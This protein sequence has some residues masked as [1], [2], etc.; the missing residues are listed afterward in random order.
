MGAFFLLDADTRDQYLRLI[1]SV[2]LLLGLLTV[3]VLRSFAVALPPPSGKAVTAEEAP[4]LFSLL[5]EVRLKLGAPSLD[6]V[7]ISD[8]LNA[9][10]TQTRRLGLIGPARNSLRMGLPLLEGLGLDEIKAVIAHEY[11]HLAGA[12]GRMSTWVYFLRQRLGNLAINF[13]SSG[14]RI[15]DR[16]LKW[17]IPF[18]NAH[19]LVLVRELELR[20]DQVAARAVGPGAIGLSLVRLDLMTVALERFWRSFWTAAD[21]GERQPTS[22][23]YDRMGASLRDGRDPVNEQRTLTHCLGLE[24]DTSHM[25]P[26]LSDRLSSLRA[27]PELPPKIGASA[28]EDLLGPSYAAVVSYWNDKW[29]EAARET[30]EA[31]HAEAERLRVELAGLEKRAPAD[32]KTVELLRLAALHERIEDA[33]RAVK[34]YREALSREPEMS[35]ALFGLGKLLLQKDDPEGVELLERAGWKAILPA[36]GFIERYFLRRGD[37][38][39]AKVWRQKV[40]TAAE[41]LAAA[42]VERANIA[43]DATLATHGWSDEEVHALA[44]QLAAVKGL[45][46]AWLARIEVRYLPEEPCYMLLVEP[47]SR[48][49]F[50]F[51]HQMGLNLHVAHAVHTTRRCLI[52]HGGRRSRLRQ[53]LAGVAN[54]LVYDR[55]TPGARSSP[56]SITARMG[57][58]R[59][60]VCRAEASDEAGE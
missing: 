41:E 29:W 8:E 59:A 53:R 11:A 42:Q 55:P 57:G 24:H 47:R 2:T 20:A 27:E 46:R 38:A 45:K 40:A 7:L 12:H 13:A 22:R 5:E 6:A 35:E 30:W 34:F 10:V 19:S 39:T 48:V 52:A 49:W 18:F 36:G 32:L 51:A 9:G 56:A 31:R 58:S 43:D 4:R 54:S 14:P 50:L 26:T 3:Q 21:R 16:F 60:E 44:S 28:A 15:F 1:L 17:F 37:R 33:E 25:H 23:P